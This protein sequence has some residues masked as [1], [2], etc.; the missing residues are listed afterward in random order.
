MKQNNDHYRTELSAEKLERYVARAQVL[1]RGFDNVSD[2]VIITD[3]NANILYAN[4]AV[5]KNTGFTSAEVVG[6]NPGDLWG[7]EMPQDYYEKM[8]RRIKVDKQPFV[9]EVHNRRKDGS[10]YWQEIHISPVLGEHGDV[11]FFIGIEPNIT[12]RKER[13]KFRDEFISVLA[14]QLQSPLTAV[15]WAVEWLSKHGGLAAKQQATISAIYRSNESLIHL[16]AD[17]LACARIG[18]VETKK[19]TVD[20]AGEIEAIVADIA[21]RM[22]AVSL[23]FEKK[24]AVVVTA[25][26]SLASQVFGNLISNAAEYAD[27][28]AGRVKVVL[29]R[30]GSEYIFS[31]ENNGLHIPPEDQPKIFTKFFRA[32]NA[33]DAKQGGTGLGL[34][35]VKMICE[36]FGWKVRFE[37]PV[38]GQSGGAI[39]FVHIPVD[40]PRE[41]HQD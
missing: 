34:F 11:Q 29:Q 12:E 5:E 6:K 13:E 17:M 8:W 2:H 18:A 9:G 1:R 35:I 32:S 22:P 40:A 7:G 39:F 15:K 27:K 26:R 37:S 14:H 3:P 19:E 21:G 41:Q 10:T 36:S 28:A 23:T 30:A 4:R 33:A 38:P 24:D 16:V 25:N 20:L 31:V